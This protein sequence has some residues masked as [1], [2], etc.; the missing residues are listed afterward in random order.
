MPWIS[1]VPAVVMSWYPGQVGGYAIGQ[2]LLG[3]VNFSGKLPVTWSTVPADWPVFSVTGDTTTTMSYYLGYRWFDQMKKT[4]LYPFGH[5]LSYTTYRYENV[6]VPCNDVKADANI[7][8]TVDV[9][10][11][12]DVDGD[13]VVMVFVR[14]LDAPPAGVLRSVKELKAFRRV[15]LPKGQGKRVTIDVR[16][17]DLSV[18]D[19]TSKTMKVP[20]GRVQILVG[21]SSDR[22]K[23][24]PASDTDTSTVIT[25]AP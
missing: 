12:G 16:A 7:P 17:S 5:G 6:T 9:F 25:L 3:N 11:T 10:N 15:N 18:Y 1:M 14:F 23:L 4:P 22:T 20:A 21:P 24:L 2:L 19:P 8:V 13:E